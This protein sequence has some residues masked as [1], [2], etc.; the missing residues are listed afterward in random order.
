MLDSTT[1][2]K[3]SFF[4]HNRLQ[5][6]SNSCRC[7]WQHAVQF[8]HVHVGPVPV[9]L[10]RVHGHHDQGVAPGW[11]GRR[12][13]G[14]VAVLLAPLAVVV[15]LVHADAGA[16]GSLHGWRGRAEGPGG[17]LRGLVVGLGQEDEDEDEAED[18]NAAVDEEGNGRVGHGHVSEFKV[19]I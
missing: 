14:H 8:C 18:A 4:E 1:L 12:G 9:P 2:K 7:R 10:R 19:I 6:S 3:H 5:I 13:H 17:L 15:V 11:G 16:A